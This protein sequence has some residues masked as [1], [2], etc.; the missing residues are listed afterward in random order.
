MRSVWSVL[1]AGILTGQE[2]QPESLNPVS[3]RIPTSL[4][5]SQSRMPT[6]LVVNA[7]NIY[8]MLA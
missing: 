4:V 6:L 8:I 5:K 7:S 1:G 3:F 2:S